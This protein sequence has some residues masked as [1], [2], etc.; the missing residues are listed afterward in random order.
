M[1]RYHIRHMLSYLVASLLVLAPVAEGATRLATLRRSESQQQLLQQRRAKQP[2]T[3]KPKKISD[4]MRKSLEGKYNYLTPAEQTQQA[5]YLKKQKR[6]AEKSNNADALE[7]YRLKRTEL[8][9]SKPKST[10]LTADEQLA[11]RDAKEE[12]NRLINELIS[13]SS[14]VKKRTQLQKQIEA[15][16]TKRQTIKTGAS[17]RERT[18]AL[19]TEYE[20]GFGHGQK[21]EAKQVPQGN[22]PKDPD[23]RKSPEGQEKGAGST[24][25]EGAAQAGAKG[26][27][28]K[29][30]QSTLARGGASALAIG[31]VTAGAGVGL[32]AATNK[33]PGGHTGGD[34]PVDQVLQQMQSIISGLQTNKAAA[35]SAD[36]AQFNQMVQSAASMIDQMN[37]AQ[38]DTFSYLLGQGQGL[39]LISAKDANPIRKR[40]TQHVTA[41]QN[42]AEP[43]DQTDTDDGTVS[44]PTPRQAAPPAQAA[45]PAPRS[46]SRPAV[47]QPTSRDPFQALNNLVNSVSRRAAPTE[48]QI[49]SFY[50]QLNGLL[51]QADQLTNDQRARANDLII[52]GNQKGFI[53]NQDAVQAH[54]MLYPPQ[55]EQAAQENQS[56]L[57][58]VFYAWDETAQQ[59]L[60]QVNGAWYSAQEAG[61]WQDDKTGQVYVGNTLVQLAE[62]DPNQDSQ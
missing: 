50:D 9:K 62:Y 16:R 19:T 24:T 54:D 45:V 48:A 17:E 53:N 52:A 8:K 26:L 31:G 49:Q 60:Y 33:G 37:G 4:Q 12:K 61:I 5:A 51:N 18:A 39:K 13:P 28:G 22:Y 38:C 41:L 46:A 11:L 35:S 3:A 15:V 40:I 14:D 47:Q 29:V 59:E 27:V 55:D 21:G 25:A 56:D 32:D 10:A 34:S 36:I 23:A 20:R 1:F 43:G 44:A 2:Q 6:R 58:V 7:Y 42:A 30:A 57:P